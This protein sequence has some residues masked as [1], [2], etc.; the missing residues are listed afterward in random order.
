MILGGLGP[1]KESALTSQLLCGSLSHWQ[2][3]MVTF[4]IGGGNVFIKCHLFN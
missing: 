3:K 4:L 1:L 2:Y